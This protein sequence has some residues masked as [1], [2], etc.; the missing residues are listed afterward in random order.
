MAARD[1]KNEVFVQSKGNFEEIVDLVLQ[2]CIFKKKKICAVEKGGFCKGKTSELF[3]YFCSMQIP[4]LK[5]THKQSS[6][7]FND[8]KTFLSLLF[9]LFCTLAALPSFAQLKVIADGKVGIGTSTPTQAL[10]VNGQVKSTGRFFLLG[11]NAGVNE[12]GVLAGFQRTT[13]GAAAIRFYNA[14]GNFDSWGTTFGLDATGGG[15]LFHKG[16]GNLLIVTQNTNSLD[17]GVNNVAKVRLQGSNGYVGINTMTPGFQ[18]EVN[19]TAGKPGGGDWTA[20]SDRRL[21]KDVKPFRDGLDKILQ[22]EP[23]F[24]KYNGEGGLNADG[25]EYV[26]VIAQE[27]QKVAPYTIGTFTHKTIESALEDGNM[28]PTERVTDEETYLTYDGTAVTYMLVNAIKEQ[29]RLIDEKDSK[30]NELE[31]RL[32]KL[33]NLVANLGNANPINIQSIE[34]SNQ[35]SGF[36]LQNQPN[37]F[38]QATTI[39]YQLPENA[40]NSM[41]R[42]VDNNGRLLKEVKLSTDRQGEVLI[43]ASELSAGTYSY[44]LIVDGRTV[45]TR[46]MVLT[47]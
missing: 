33:E 15:G 5:S 7:K 36:L 43:H 2:L 42:V 31:E 37:P 17:L 32:T 28:V 27:M 3:F 25:K 47:K 18:L 14:P 39:R 9:S 12:A 30:I 34:L 22:I 45:E 11:A 44:S 10:E 16:N 41:L 6:F 8:M 26:G 1:K 29:Q 21:K 46:Q 13:T 24:F 4:S 20:A 38:N 19:G 35:N 23:V 40:K